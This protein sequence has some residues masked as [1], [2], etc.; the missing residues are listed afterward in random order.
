MRHIFLS[1]LYAYTSTGN[2]QSYRLMVTP[3]YIMTMTNYFLFAYKITDEG[4]VEDKEM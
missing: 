3:L 4:V 1:D 2:N